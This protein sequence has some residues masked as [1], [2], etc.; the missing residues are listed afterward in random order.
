[1][2][3]E[4]ATAYAMVETVNNLLQPTAQA[5]W[6]GLSTGAQLRAATTLLD[7][8]EQGAFVLAD[9]LLKTD[10]VQENT[11]NIQLEVARMSTEGTLPD[12]RFPQSGGQGNSIHLSANTLKQ[13]GRNGEIRIAFVLYKHIGAYLSTENASVKLGHE[14]M[15][16][17]HSVIVNSPV[18][19]AAINK[20][21]NKVYLSDP[22][23]FTMRHLQRI[24]ERRE[25]A[26]I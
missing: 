13:H 21:T 3:A 9:N 5:A 20:D 26:S 1:M 25:I 19:T 11:D 2:A 8:V 23:I 22:V 6:R 15:A 24:K 4:D 7:T 14:A 18:I 12:L 16:T 17:N 10:I